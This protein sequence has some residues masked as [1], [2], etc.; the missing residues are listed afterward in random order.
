MKAQ[1]PERCAC[2]ACADGRDHPER[3]LHRQ[4]QLLLSRLDEG[5]RRWDAAVAA[6]RLGPGSVRRVADSTGLDEHTIRRGQQEVAG[7]LADVPVRRQRRSGGGRPPVEKGI[8][9]S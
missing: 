9:P 5:Q 4:L 2:P 6:T 8:R 1:D 3:V 7:S